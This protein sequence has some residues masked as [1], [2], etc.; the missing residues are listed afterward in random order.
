MRRLMPRSTKKAFT[1]I[2]LS[3]VLATFALLA[4][5][6]VPS[7]GVQRSGNER[8]VCVNNLKRLGEAFLQYSEDVSPRFMPQFSFRIASAQGGTLGAYGVVRHLVVL[9]N[10]LSS[11]SL[12][13]CPSTGRKPATSFRIVGEP[14]TTYV[15]GAHAS[16][17]DSSRVL[18]AD[19]DIEGSDGGQSCS[20]LNNLFVAAFNGAPSHPETWGAAWSATNHVREGQVLLSDGSVVATSSRQLKTLFA[21]DA[22]ASSLNSVHFVYSR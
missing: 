7:F 16:P 20:L 18:L 5:V 11:P 15:I 22:A 13:V 10:Y 2:E 21:Q 14:D 4:G 12:L 6:L 8:T 1:R 3:M 9:S 17:L 19:K